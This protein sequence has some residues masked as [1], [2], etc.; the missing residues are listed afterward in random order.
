MI[1]L[2]ASLDH[3]HEINGTWRTEFGSMWWFSKGHK[4]YMG[5][6]MISNKERQKENFLQHKDV[7]VSSAYPRVFA[8]LADLTFWGWKLLK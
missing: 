4:R 5:G 3:S 7:F 1:H 2:W 8:S 6:L